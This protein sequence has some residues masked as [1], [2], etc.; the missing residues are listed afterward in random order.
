MTSQHKTGTHP[1]LWQDSI[2]PYSSIFMTSW[3]KTGAHPF[4]IGMY[5]HIYTHI[6]VHKYTSQ[7]ECLH[8]FLVSQHPQPP[9]PRQKHHQIPTPFH[10]PNSVPP[11]PQLPHGRGPCTRDRHWAVHLWDL[12]PL[13]PNERSGQWPAVKA[14]RFSVEFTRESGWIEPK[15]GRCWKYFF[16]G[17]TGPRFSGNCSN[18][19]EH[20]CFFVG[21]PVSW[22]FVLSPLSPGIDSYPTAVVYRMEWRW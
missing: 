17:K 10:M 8:I 13:H 16:G 7:K 20:R 5:I 9:F 6:Y 18:P 4:Y 22:R 14:W 2:I 19:M 1:F 15:S 3:H 11:N 12:H 21:A